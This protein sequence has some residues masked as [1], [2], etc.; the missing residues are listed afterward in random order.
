MLRIQPDT[1]MIAFSQGVYVQVSGFN[2]F[3]KHH[4]RNLVRVFVG[5][6]PSGLAPPWQKPI[7][8]STAVARPRTDNPLESYHGY[9]CRSRTNHPVESRSCRTYL[10]ETRCGQTQRPYQYYRESLEYLIPMGFGP[11]VEDASGEMPW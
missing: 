6:F 5:P 11:G 10:G 4:G 2:N 8:G 7:P 1:A 3:D 9:C